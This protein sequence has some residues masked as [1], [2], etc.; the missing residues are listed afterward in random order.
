MD[1]VKGRLVYFE[2]VDGAG[3]GVVLS[4]A[5]RVTGYTSDKVTFSAWNE[6]SLGGSARPILL[7]D[8]SQVINELTSAKNLS[9]IYSDL[10]AE[11]EALATDDFEAIRHYVSCRLFPLVIANTYHEIWRPALRSGRDV[12][13]DRGL[14]GYLA[15]QVYAGGLSEAAAVENIEEAFAFYGY[16]SSVAFDFSCFFVSINKKV[17]QAAMNERAQS[18]GQIDHNDTDLSLQE[19]LPSAYASATD[20]LSHNYGIKTVEFDN[21]TRYNLESKVSRSR[22]LNKLKSTLN[23]MFLRQLDFTRY[24]RELAEAASDLKKTIN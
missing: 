19:K 10:A 5:S 17:A 2:G 8:P 18:T 7:A 24:P 22:F 9:P 4:Q 21:S 15:Y 3:K 20:F 12:F 11:V 13:A 16:D 6:G 23:S 1:T 14:P